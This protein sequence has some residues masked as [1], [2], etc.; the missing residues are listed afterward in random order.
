MNYTR[1]PLAIGLEPIKKAFLDAKNRGVHLRYLTEITKDNLPYCKE[2]ME[3]VHELR[4]LDGIK[5]NFMVSESEYIA[6]L[7]LFEHEKIA[8]QAVYSNIK[9]VVE[10]EHY[11]FDNF[12]NKAISAQE[13]IKEIEEGRAIHYETKILRN[14]DEIVNKIRDM[15]QT[16]NELLVC[17]RSGGLRLGYERFLA[18][19]KE[20]LAKSRRGKH[21]GIRLVTAAIDRDSVELVKILL[22]MG[23]QIRDIKSMPPMNFSVTNKEVQATIEKMEGGTMAQSTLVSN[24]PIYVNHFHSIFEELWKDGLDAKARI[25]NIEEGVD[26]GDIEVIP[27]SAR[28]REVYLNLVKKAKEEI[29]IIFPTSGAFIRQS[30]FGVIE[31]AKEAARLRNTKVRILMPASK[32]TDQM[33]IDLK[34]DVRYHVEQTSA[35]K[36]T[37]LVVDRKDSLVMEL[38]D[39][40]TTTFEEAI[41]FSTHSNSRPGVLSYVAIF[42]NIWRQTEMFEQLKIHD[43]MQ[44]EF[45]NVAAHE[46]RTPMQPIISLTEVLRSQIKD[47][48]Q[49]EMLEI[50]IRNAKRLQRLT[51]DIL[52]VTKIEGGSLELNKEDF[53]LNDV[54]INAMNDITLGRDFLNNEN[55]KLSYNPHRDIL[56]RADKERISQV[57]SNLL[58]NAIKFTAEGTILVSVEKEK[59]SNNTLIPL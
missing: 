12:W 38:R 43:R 45:I 30:K 2:L 41:G 58:S 42:E 9:E 28:A 31:L 40:S 52:D 18:L 46:L 29:M 20:I 8:P 49:H 17:T 55:I 53:N 27:N 48:K 7:I 56:I 21:K 3:I 13:R 54:V 22:D 36:A 26:I 44:Q 35:A 59:A 33:I 19:G 6:P 50:T 32:L 57:L 47:V 24:E 4:H 16:S 14:Q 11:I 34:R 25:Q 5:G 15:L 51:N 10:H 1:P 23:I 37:I 39:D